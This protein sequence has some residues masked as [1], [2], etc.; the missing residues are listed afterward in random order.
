MGGLVNARLARAGGRWAS[1]A[2]WACA[3]WWRAPTDL[4]TYQLD[5]EYTIAR[6]LLPGTGR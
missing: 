4:D 3:A 2:P 1:T 5:A 6:L